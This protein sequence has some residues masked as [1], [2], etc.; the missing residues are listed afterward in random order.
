MRNPKVFRA[1]A[2]G[3]ALGLGI[4]TAAA[5]ADGEGEGP[6]KQPVKKVVIVDQDGK[7]VYEGEGP[8]MRRGYLGVALT[9]LSPELRTHFGVAGD[10]GVMVAKVEAG[11]PAEK[12]GIKVGD[13]VSRI[14]GKEVES[15]WDVSAKVRRFDDGQQIPVEIWRNGKAQNV[16]VTIVQKERPE[17]DMAPF[18]FKE[19]GD[20]GF[21][22]D[23]EAF[24]GLKDKAFADGWGQKDVQIRHLGSPRE[25]EL[26]KELKALEKRIAELEKQIKKQ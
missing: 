12:A 19:K 11:S 7:K 15:S 23:P 9:E 16:T 4:L 26:E 2:W 10:A 13:I 21:K 17:L 24:K 5:H 1:A 6:G 18:F 3:L 14:D 25:A 20:F 8:M 22:M